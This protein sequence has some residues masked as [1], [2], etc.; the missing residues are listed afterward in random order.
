MTWFERI[1]RFCSQDTLF[2]KIICWFF[3]GFLVGGVLLGGVVPYFLG[4]WFDEEKYW[5]RL[6]S[7]IDSPQL[8]IKIS[9]NNENSEKTF[10]I[11]VSYEK[12]LDIK[13]EVANKKDAENTF[14]IS[15]DKVA[16]GEPVYF[17]VSLNG[18]VCGTF[19]KQMG[20]AEILLIDECE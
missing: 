19:N 14:L 4:K 1:N 12:E 10:S 9:S 7:I 15:C 3:S 6:K 13:C 11:S 2:S 8:E 17:N 18:M 20:S 5:N 16:I